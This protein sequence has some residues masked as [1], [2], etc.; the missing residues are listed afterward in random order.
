MKKAYIFSILFLISVVMNAQDYKLFGASNGNKVQLKWMSKNLKNNTSFDVYRSESNGSWQKLNNEPIVPSPVITQAE[1][2]SSKNQ[3]P[4]D[5]SYEFYIKT[6]NS[7]ETVA[8]KKAYELYQLSLAAI[9]DSQ[10]AKHLGIYFEDNS[11]TAGKKYNYK[12]VDVSSSKEL[13]VLNGLIV[14]DVPVAPENFKG[15]Q[16]NQNVKLS[17]KM[18]D[19][20]MGCNIYRNGTKIN[21]EPIMANLEKDGYQIG[22][23]DSNLAEG[24]YVYVLKGVTFLNTES[25]ASAEVK[26]VVKD[27]TPPSVIKGFKAERKNDEVVLVWQAVKDKDLS[28]YN[29]LKST[30]KGKTFVKVNTQLIS[31]VSFIEKIDGASGTF[32]YQIEA[33]DKSNNTRKSIPVNVFVPDH[34]APDMPKEVSSKSES[35]KITLS[36]RANSENDLAGYRIYRGL[37]DDDE[38][39]MLLLNVAPQAQTFFVDTFNEKAGTKFIYKVTA[40][41]RSFNESPQAVVWVQ[42][43]DVVPPS[44]PFLQEATYE[45]NQVN[46]KWDA[47]VNDAILGYDVYRVFEE[48]EEKI[49]REPVLST[50]FTDSEN[51]KKGIIQYYIKAIDSA[52]LVSKP[53]NKISVATADFANDKLI[54]TL[55]QDLRAK[56]VTISYEGLKSQDIQTI[57]LFRKSEETGFVRVPFLINDN[58]IVD[59]TSEENK[60]YE[61]Y[62]EVLTVDDTKLKSQKET[63][64]NTF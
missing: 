49:N 46:L 59:E 26:L 39:E 38:N 41:D 50:N 37:K 56:K 29:V 5:K 43:P 35:G 16:E 64:N 21:T 60:I 58:V 11:A 32:Q 8:N 28:G 13:S 55:S 23:I 19:N 6:K 2:M 62:L 52:K 1:L 15:I 7:K 10:V 3:F 48:R 42:L 54:I 12:V 30:D 22:Y 27:A 44:A 36:W 34:T 33:V 4:N 47:V 53:S 61:Y 18:N 20:F 17:W 57:K 14:G 24:S 40:V 63:I 51:S 9:F 45:R 31:S 25:Q